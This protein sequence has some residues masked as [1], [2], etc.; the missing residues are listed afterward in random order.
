MRYFAFLV[1]VFAVASVCSAQRDRVVDTA[2]PGQPRGAE[3]AEF[4]E[5][6]SWTLSDPGNPLGWS[7]KVPLKEQTTAKE[8]E[9]LIETAAAD[10]T[11]EK[12]EEEAEEDLV[13]KIGGNYFQ[14]IIA[15]LPC[16]SKSFCF[17]NGDTYCSDGICVFLSSIIDSFNNFDQ[18]TTRANFD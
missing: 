13:N 16:C 12:D 9:A 15:D 18:A 6:N 1:F 17:C 11:T 5:E 3:V 14:E 4:R 10:E 2:F 7:L 8:F